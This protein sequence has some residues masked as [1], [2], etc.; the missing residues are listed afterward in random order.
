MY[1]KRFE[2]IFITVFF[3]RSYITKD[4]FVVIF[5]RKKNQYLLLGVSFFWNYKKSNKSMSHKRASGR[6]EREK[7]YSE[8]ARLENATC[9]RASPNGN[10]FA[11][12]G[13]RFNI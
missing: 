9:Y 5:S 11:R 6:V 2:S 8:D 7:R 3:F 12:S 10:V 1:T 13:N 4:R